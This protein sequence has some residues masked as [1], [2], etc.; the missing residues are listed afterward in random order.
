MR[1]AS[2]RSLFSGAARRGFSSF[3]GR[4]E[5]AR[6]IVVFDHVLNLPLAGLRRGEGQLRGREGKGRGKGEDG[7]GGQPKW[8]VRG[9]V[10]GK[11]GDVKSE[12]GCRT[13]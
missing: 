13:G 7:V 10:T 5:G 12:M 6:H 9:W 2:D 8:R 11:D 1:A 4:A 3:S